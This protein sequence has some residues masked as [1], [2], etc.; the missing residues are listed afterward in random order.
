MTAPG[1]LVK[2][3][4]KGEVLHF[5]DFLLERA[6]QPPGRIFKSSFSSFDSK[7]QGIK[8]GEVFVITGKKKNGKSLFAESWIYSLMKNN[9]GEAK[10]LIL[11]YENESEQLLSKYQKDETVPLYL[12]R[13][14]ET[15]NFDWLHD[16]CMEAKLKFNCRILLIDHLH[17]M[18]DMNTKQ[19]MSL[20]IGAFMRRLK[21]D[22]ANGLGLAVILIAHSQSLK[23]DEEASSDTMRDSSFIG[24]ECDS[25]IVVSRKKNY[26]QKELD[27]IMERDLN[28]YASIKERNTR[29]Q[30]YFD[31]E[32]E[33]PY[34]AGFCKVRVDV[35]RRTGVYGWEKI[36]Q[37]SGNWLE[38]I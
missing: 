28:K 22:I 31:A 27:K 32:D 29:V 1:D 23:E 5:T 9:P 3:D 14:L 26:T 36:F 8:T 21:H 24:Q 12:P 18:V 15:M 11:S 17:F 16:R 33:N 6:T 38:E 34:S 25:V 30:A 7:I 13:Q 20:N 4:G 35:N 2:N 37:K 19:N 10:T